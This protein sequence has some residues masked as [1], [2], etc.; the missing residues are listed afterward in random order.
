MRNTADYKII[1]I[2]MDT[3]IT[4]TAHKS[5]FASLPYSALTLNIH[6]SSVGEYITHHTLPNHPDNISQSQPRP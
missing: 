3:L 5:S 4:E 6:A 1:V 2:N